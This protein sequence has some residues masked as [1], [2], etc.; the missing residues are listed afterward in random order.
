M[1]PSRIPDSPKSAA[2]G[3]LERSGFASFWGLLS[4]SWIL[5]FGRIAVLGFGEIYRSI[6]TYVCMHVCVYMQK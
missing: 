2:P 3:L 5:A 6:C 4:L 1:C